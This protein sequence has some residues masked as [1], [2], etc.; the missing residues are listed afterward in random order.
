[1]NLGTGN[2]NIAISAG[3]ARLFGDSISR[4]GV[5]S[6]ALAGQRGCSI[7]CVDGTGITA[8]GG[9]NYFIGAF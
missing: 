3:T 9:N 1:M 5:T 8:I 7:T 4:A 2:V 6:F